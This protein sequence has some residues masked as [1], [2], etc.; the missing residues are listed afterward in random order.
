MEN[1]YL[2]T[3]HRGAFGNKYKATPYHS[4]MDKER[5]T[6]CFKRHN[7]NAVFMSPSE[8]DFRDKKYKVKPL[9][10][11]NYLSWGTPTDYESYQ[12]KYFS[13]FF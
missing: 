9:K 3:N 12:K 5:L 7:Y 4:G 6:T 11:D 13:E 8:L 1:I 10:V 2:L